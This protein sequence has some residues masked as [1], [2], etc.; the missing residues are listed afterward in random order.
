MRLIFFSLICMNLACAIR[1]PAQADFQ[2]LTYYEDD[3]NR[4]QL[5]LFLPDGADSIGVPLLIYV[6]G[7][8]FSGGNRR[9]GHTIGRYLRDRGIATASISY[10]LLMRNR[11]FSCGGVTSEKIRAIRTAV[12][13]TWLATSFL[14]ERSELLGI[15][16]DQIFLGGASAGAETILHA[17]YWVDVLVEEY[18]QQLPDDFEYAGLIGGAGAIVDINLI[19]E[20]NHIPSL[21]F[22]GDMDPLVPYG[23]AAHHYCPPTASGWLMLFGSNAIFEHLESLSGTVKLISHIG[24]GHEIAGYYFNG[25][26]R[27]QVYDFIER[28]LEG[29]QFVSHLVR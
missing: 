23:I 9:E 20:K 19:S 5:D 17:P 15:Q 11:D 22:H 14:L 27:E 24:A 18:G 25:S 13:D 6:H 4:L 28:V 12:Y 21:L 16:K 1:L 29:E 2:T 8:G 7:G 10:T 26:A 3:L